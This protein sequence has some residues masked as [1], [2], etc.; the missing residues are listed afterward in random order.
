MRVLLVE[1]EERLAEN[2]ARY[3]R[4]DPVTQW[5]WQQTALRGYTLP[6]PVLTI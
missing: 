2:L 1:D 3:L 6:N 4:E 5:T